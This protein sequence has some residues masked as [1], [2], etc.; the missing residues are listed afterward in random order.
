MTETCPDTLNNHIVI[1]A[2][3]NLRFKR[4]HVLARE[5]RERRERGQTLIEG[6]HLI[7]EALAAGIHPRTWILTPDAPR[8]PAADSEAE[9]IR[10]APGLFKALT[11]TVNPAGPLA[12]IDIPLRRVAN[13]RFALLVETVQDPGN[14]GALLRTAAAA[15]VDG[16][17]LSPGCAEAWSPKALRGGQ[18]AQFRLTMVENADLTA[19]IRQFGGPVHAAAPGAETTLFDLDLRGPCAFVVGN[20]GAGLSPA[21]LALSRPFRIPMP[22]GSESLNVAAAAAIALFE[23][24]RQT[25][26]A[27]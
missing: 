20:E 18:G 6:E 1:T 14:L 5:G 24:V 4:L 8:P 21:V 2:R 15:G 17:Y 27:Q 25:R 3:D 23:H 13:P 10:L 12:V 11:S 9:V 26:S 16:V 22:G 19:A 7:A